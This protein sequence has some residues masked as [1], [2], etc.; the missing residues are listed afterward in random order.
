MAPSALS[1]AQS[2]VPLD[3]FFDAVAS[4]DVTS[5]LLLRPQGRQ[6][7]VLLGPFEEPQI[8]GLTEPFNLTLR[9]IATFLPEL[10]GYVDRFSFLP[11]WQ[12]E[13]PTLSY[14]A[15]QAP[16][17]PY[18]ND[19]DSFFINLGEDLVFEFDSGEVEPE[20][21]SYLPIAVVDNFKPVQHFSVKSGSLVYLPAG[22]NYRHT[23]TLV[24][25]LACH[26][27]KRSELM[28]DWLAVCQS[29]PRLRPWAEDGD[30]AEITP[31]TVEKFR[32][33]LESALAEP[34]FPLWCA[35][36]VTSGTGPPVEAMDEP[37]ELAQFVHYLEDSPE[38]ERSDQVRWGYFQQDDESVLLVN[39]FAF[40]APLEVAKMLAKNRILQ[41]SKLTGCEPLLCELYNR[42]YL[43]FFQDFED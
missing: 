6:W 31:Q 14:S 9:G 8:R 21:L 4:E 30:G 42:G 35:R 27:P 17:G 1:Y 24:L 18:P 7:D 3:F 28:T 41:V 20:F 40:A 2:L 22:Y 5:T 33:L 32:T 38:L 11:D 23:G 37:L 15:I 39:G 10:Q 19:T 13:E 29:D 16:R 43:D 12:K 36:Y 26:S 34:D 25:V